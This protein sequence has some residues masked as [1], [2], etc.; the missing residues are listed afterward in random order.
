VSQFKDD[1]SKAS[2]VLSVLPNYT[3]LLSL[4][5]QAAINIDE[6]K[7]D[8]YESR[9]KYYEECQPIYLSLKKIVHELDVARPL[10][11]G[12]I[13]ERRVK[14][15]ERQLQDKKE[16]RKFII[17]VVVTLVAGILSVA[18]GWLFE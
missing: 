10:I 2:D 15:E 11:N 16:T 12:L 8:H 13:E 6:V 1:Y 7:S 9:D 18:Y 14:I 4:A 3:A 5:E 17:M